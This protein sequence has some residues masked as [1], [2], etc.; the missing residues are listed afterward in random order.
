MVLFLISFRE[1]RSCWCKGHTLNRKALVQFSECGPGPASSGSLGNLLDMYVLRLHSNIK[2]SDSEAHKSVRDHL[3]PPL[4]LH[5]LCHYLSSSVHQISLR[6]PESFLTGVSPS[7]LI[8]LQA[9][10]HS[11]TTIFKLKIGRFCHPQIS[12][13]LPFPCKIKS[14]ICNL[15][16]IDYIK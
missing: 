6:K 13:M 14:N 4:S 7:N 12:L 3:K 5:S 2:N 11:G 9:I 15:D 16:F 8:L 1:C 10:F